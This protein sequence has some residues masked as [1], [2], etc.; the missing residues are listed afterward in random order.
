M[1]GMNTTR[2]GQ[3]TIEYILL[4]ATVAAVTLVSMTTFDD[5]IM[6]ALGD[7]FTKAADD[8]SQSFIPGW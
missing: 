1:R 8:M 7:F 2:S 3:I 4:L 6:S 5:Q